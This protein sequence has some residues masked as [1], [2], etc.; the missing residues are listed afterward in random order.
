MNDAFQTK[1]EEIE[2]EFR[3]VVNPVIR[4]CPAGR[5]RTR[6][7]QQIAN[8]LG[9]LATGVNPTQPT[10]SSDVRERER[11]REIGDRPRSQRPILGEPRWD[12]NWSTIYRSQAT[13]SAA[14]QGNPQ[15]D[16]AAIIN[17]DRVSELLWTRSDIKRTWP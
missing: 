15:A 12:K 7:P 16:L 13:T 11:E 3:T 8:Y 6:V 10:F 2:E 1:I 5:I 17:T 4:G 14:T 9:P